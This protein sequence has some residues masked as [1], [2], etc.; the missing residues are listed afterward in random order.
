MIRVIC[1]D[2]SAL[3]P[4]DYQALYEKASAER[5]VR[6]D[7]YRRWE[8]SLRCVVADALLR[9]AL[10]TCEY[11]VEK[12][13]SGKPF[14]KGRE[15]FHYNLSHSGNWVVIAFGDT[16]VGVDVEKPRTNIDMDAIAR[17][18]FA[19]EEQRYVFKEETNRVSRFCEIWTGKESYLKYMGTGL[20]K[21]LTSF[22]VLSLEP[23]IR[24]HYQTLPGGYSLCLCT[25]EMDYLFEL[26]DLQRL[27]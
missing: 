22:N 14:I 7:R 13:A 24:L 27:L 21:D 6:A 11:T 9:H 18:F 4:S 2:I 8:D 15:N 26:L 16:E 25:T 5:K 20:K 10:G 3:S 17:R 12:T 23:E 1:T 19:T